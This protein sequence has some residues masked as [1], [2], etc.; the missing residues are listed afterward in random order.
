MQPCALCISGDSGVHA[1]ARRTISTAS[2]RSPAGIAANCFG[3]LGCRRRRPS[4]RSRLGASAANRSPGVALRSLFGCVPRPRPSIR[5]RLPFAPFALAHLRA[6]SLS[7]AVVAALCPVSVGLDR[8]RRRAAGGAREDGAD[9]RP[10]LWFRLMRRIPQRGRACHA[11]LTYAWR[12]LRFRVGRFG[13]H[14]PTEAA[15]Q[16][17][18]RAKLTDY[19]NLLNLPNLLNLLPLF[20]L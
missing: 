7:T 19:L 4:L 5:W 11:I 18:G 20:M 10:P 13:H 17:Y 2:G 3:V 9:R 8:W 16:K 1:T 12:P 14:P 15:P 6:C